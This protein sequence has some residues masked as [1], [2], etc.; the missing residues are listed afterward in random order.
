MRRLSIQRLRRRLGLRPIGFGLA[1]GAAALL[2][3]V[4]DLVESAQWL[5]RELRGANRY[6]ALIIRMLLSP[7][8]YAAVS[9]ATTL[10]L[11]IKIGMQPSESRTESFIEIVEKWIC[12]AKDLL[13]QPQLTMIEIETWKQKTALDLAALVGHGSVLATFRQ[14]GQLLGSE[15]EAGESGLRAVLKREIRFLQEMIDRADRGQID[16]DLP[17]HEL[18]SR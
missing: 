6:V 5:E 1:T 2:I 8:F 14:A 17:L 12:S 4:H 11:I 16:F 10:Y 9:L 13:I 18:G 7:A 3:W 15:Y